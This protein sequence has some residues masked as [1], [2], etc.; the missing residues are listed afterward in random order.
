MKK[1]IPAFP[2]EKYDYR[3]LSKLDYLAA[4]AMQGMIV[5]L[6]NINSELIARLS[7]NIAEAML[8]ES[9][10]RHNETEIETSQSQHAE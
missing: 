3:G 4:K 8:E 7:Y 5:G 9:Y 2:V 6:E 10:R 1:Y